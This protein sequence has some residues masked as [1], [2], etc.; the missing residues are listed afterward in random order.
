MNQ[1]AKK[2]FDEESE[3]RPTVDSFLSQESGLEPSSNY[4]QSY[5]F[6]EVVQVGNE[7]NEIAMKIER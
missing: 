4:N 2:E 6:I 1:V 7:D 5:S 3:I